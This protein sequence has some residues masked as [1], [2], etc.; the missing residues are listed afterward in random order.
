M[1][2]F[3]DGASLLNTAREEIGATFTY[4]Y[5][6]G[7]EVDITGAVGFTVWESDQLNLG[8]ILKRSV[9]FIFDSTYCVVNG[10]LKE[11][12]KGDM[13]RSEHTGEI[14][15]YEVLPELGESHFTPHDPRHDSY[16]VHT[17]EIGIVR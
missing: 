8:F 5:K 16:R 11:P 1:G 13:I 12:K 3:Q 4:I 15:D 7:P 17:K 10:V 2:L 9:D 6:D 14:R